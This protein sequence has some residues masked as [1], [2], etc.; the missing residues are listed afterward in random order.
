MTYLTVHHI[1]TISYKAG[2]KIDI[3]GAIFYF[4]VCEVLSVDEAGTANVSRL[5]GDYVYD[6]FLEYYT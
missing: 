6:Q 3:N 4:L 2:D 1:K 5:R